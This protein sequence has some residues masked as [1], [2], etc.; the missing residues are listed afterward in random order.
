MDAVKA[1]RARGI[2]NPEELLQY[3]TLEAIRGACQWWDGK[4]GVGAGLLAKKIREGGIDPEPRP[5]PGS[6][7]ERQRA[8]HADSARRFPVGSVEPHARLQQ[9]RWPDDEP[10]PGSMIVVTHDC[11]SWIL[12]CNRCG[13][14]VGLSLRAMAIVLPRRLEAI[15]S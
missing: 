2:D 5:A 12:E 6:V 4:P 8:T 7:E 1:M 3:A 10:C 13:F 15:A 11:P 14:E 9:R